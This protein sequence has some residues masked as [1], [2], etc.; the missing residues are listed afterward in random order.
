MQKRTFFSLLLGGII[1]VIFVLIH[2]KYTTEYGE[3]LKYSNLKPYKDV[4]K[5][6]SNNGQTHKQVMYNIL[7]ST[8]I[9]L[10][11]VNIKPIIMFST[12]LGHARHNDL[13]PWDDRVDICVSDSDM[14]KILGLQGF[15]KYGLN[16]K[17]IPKLGILRV[18]NSIESWPY[19]NI[20]GYTINGSQVLVNGVDK[21]YTFNVN[22]LL[23]IKRATFARQVAIYV[24]NN[25]SAILDVIYGKNWL[26]ECESAS[27]N[28]QNDELVPK[29]YKTMCENA[30]TKIDN[31]ILDHVY[32]INLDRR[33]DRWEKTKNRLNEIGIEPKR[34]RAIDGKNNPLYAKYEKGAKL[35]KS[36]AACFDSHISLWKYIYES[37]I[38]SALIFEDDIFITPGTT[39][40][41]ILADVDSSG[42][43][44]I[45]FLG[46][47]YSSLGKFSD[48]PAKIGTALALHAY[49]INRSTIERLIPLIQEKNTPIDEITQTYC[50]NNLC[51]LS[52]HKNSGTNT[53]PCSGLIHQDFNIDSDLA[54]ERMSRRIGINVA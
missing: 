49:I 7:K 20:C 30:M 15:H 2:N 18:Y 31:K 32:V 27:W 52:R 22:D 19:V 14:D 21:K 1:I 29:Q 12:L 33:P 17:F 5:N 43:F 24:P 41:D 23:P 16:V 6:K 13:I 4:W 42:G 34:W 54:M 44:D 39:L 37:G 50:T 46:H 3:R 45:F 26:N 48:T 51:F 38:P 25:T 28:S 40:D 53:D 10:E 36:E 11:N 47:I 35:S 8:C 9:V